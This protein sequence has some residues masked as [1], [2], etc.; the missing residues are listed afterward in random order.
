MEVYKALPVDA[1]AT[2]ATVCVADDWYR[3]P[4]AFFLP[5]PHYRLRFLKTTFDGPQPPSPLSPPF[6]SQPPCAIRATPSNRSRLRQQANPPP[7]LF[8]RHAAGRL[9]G[10]AGRHGVG[11]AGTER[12]Q[13]RGNRV[14]RQ[15][16]K[17][18]NPRSHVSTG[19]PSVGWHQLLP[20]GSSTYLLPALSLPVESAAVGITLLSGAAARRRSATI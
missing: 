6:T 10:G 15:A 18:P 19:T 7:L 2:Q 16:G 12:W 5:S 17:G 14:L 20:R 13:P 11:L 1:S 8:H 9:R 3:F 4:S